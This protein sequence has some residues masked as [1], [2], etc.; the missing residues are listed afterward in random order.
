MRGN[1]ENKV[2]IDTNCL[3]SYIGAKYGIYKDK[4]H[5]TAAIQYLCKQHGKQLYIS[6]LAVAQVTAT[7][8]RR[9]NSKDLQKELH[10]LIQH[11]KV[12]DFTIEDI[13][14]ALRYKKLHEEGMDIEDL[15]QYVMSLK[16]KCL[17]I[18]TNNTKDFSPL[19][20]IRSFKPKD[21]RSNIY[22]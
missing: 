14:T 13:K 20:Q 7:L 22:G 19:V 18:M 11:F 2:F 1:A 21:V 16:L 17:Y 3:I 15:Y 6:S 8:Q 9:L 4:N 5:N 12:I 10:N